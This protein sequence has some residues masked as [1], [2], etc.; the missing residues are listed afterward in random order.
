MA[1]PRGGATLSY[2]DNGDDT[3]TDNNTGLVWKKQS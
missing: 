2:T 3:I 1:I